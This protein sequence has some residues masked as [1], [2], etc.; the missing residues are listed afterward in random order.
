ME[1]RKCMRTISDE[2]DRSHHAACQLRLRDSARDNQRLLL[3][4][5]RDLVR[6][7]QLNKQTIQHTCSPISWF[8]V[9]AVQLVFEHVLYILETAASSTRTARW[10]AWVRPVLGLVLLPTRLSLVCR[11]WRQIVLKMPRLWA[12]VAHLDYS[13]TVGHKWGRS[14]MV[15]ISL[16]ANTSCWAYQKGMSPS[17]GAIALLQQA[18]DR[19]QRFHLQ[20][21]SSSDVI[22]LLSYRF[23]N[24]LELHVSFC[25]DFEPCVLMNV[26]DYHYNGLR[27]LSVSSSNAALHTELNHSTILKYKPKSVVSLPFLASLQL[28][29]V[30]YEITKYTTARL[31]APKLKE[32]TLLLDDF[33]DDTFFQRFWKEDLADV[34]HLLLGGCLTPELVQRFLVSS[35]SLRTLEL[36]ISQDRSFSDCDQIISLLDLHAYSETYAPQLEALSLGGMKVTSAVLQRMIDSRLAAPDSLLRVVQH[37]AMECDSGRPLQ[38]AIDWH[39]IRLVK[40]RSDLINDASWIGGSKETSEDCRDFSLPAA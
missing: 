7:V 8:P 37:A 10:H 31:V 38:D 12:H 13:M 39:E 22:D 15:G 6:T 3:H 40:W 32:V 19:F 2:E 36:I 27:A 17:I 24:L 26:I 30:P 16:W 29:N 28:A 18:Q 1:E 14:G 25:L 21:I 23:P 5:G 33:P 4:S 35:H 11:F 9:E 34:Q 20:E